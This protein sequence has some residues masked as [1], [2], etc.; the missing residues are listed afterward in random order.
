MR[1][2]N[3]LGNKQ[4]KIKK[5]K[6]NFIKN[7]LKFIK[8]KRFLYQSKKNIYKKKLVRLYFSLK[9]FYAKKN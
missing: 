4:K 6:K 2:L 9:Q 5:L 1:K 3:E 7:H 8:R